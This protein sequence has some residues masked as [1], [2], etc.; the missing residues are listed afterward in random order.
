MFRHVRGRHTFGDLSSQCLVYD[1]PDNQIT[2]FV[3]KS[4]MGQGIH[5]ALPIL[6]AEDLEADWRQV[7]R[8][9]RPR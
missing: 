1:Y 7:Y 8:S 4:E 3:C 5:T 6:V 2:V 9:V